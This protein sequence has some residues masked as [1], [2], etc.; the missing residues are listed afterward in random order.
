VTKT[1]TPSGGLAKFSI[2]GAGIETMP[3]DDNVKAAK[4]SSV[5]ISLTVLT[6]FGVETLRKIPAKASDT[7]WIAKNSYQYS[8]QVQLTSM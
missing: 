4:L 6:D 3:V 7:A 2:K 5:E 8:K 1:I